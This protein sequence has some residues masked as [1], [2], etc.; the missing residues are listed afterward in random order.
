MKLKDKINQ[1]FLT[2]LERAFFSAY[3]TVLLANPKYFLF[4]IKR[5]HLYIYLLEAKSA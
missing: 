5:K 3:I 2:C 1:E 4:W